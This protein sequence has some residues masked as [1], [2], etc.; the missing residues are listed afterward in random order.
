MRQSKAPKRAQPRTKPRRGRGPLVT[1]PWPG[2]DCAD[3]LM[4]GG[5][6]RKFWTA[7]SRGWR[8]PYMVAATSLQKRKAPSIQA[9]VGGFWNY[10]LLNRRKRHQYYLNLI[11]CE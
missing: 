8:G 4:P 7:A 3:V 11:P 1:W 2:R 9:Y 10:N 6:A 5:H